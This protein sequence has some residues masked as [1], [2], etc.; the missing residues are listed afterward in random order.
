MKAEIKKEG[1]LEIKTE[2]ELEFYALGQWINTNYN[3]CTG[4][5]D[6]RNICFIQNAD[7]TDTDIEKTKQ[8]FLKTYYDWL[9]TPTGGEM[10]FDEY[11]RKL[12]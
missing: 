10:P 1:L 6:G 9:K 5:I 7:G 8:L 4:G 3:K 12:K 2:T 11:I